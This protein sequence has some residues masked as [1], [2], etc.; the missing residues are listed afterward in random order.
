MTL[1]VRAD[2]SIRATVTPEQ[3]QWTPSPQPGVERV[4]LDRVGAEKARATSLVRYAPASVFPTHTHFG[5][6]EILVLE[7]T[8]S[9]ATGDYSAGY[10][11][12]NPPGS[13]HAPFSAEGALLLV[14]LSQMP[15]D[16]DNPVRV[17][18][19]DDSQWLTLG[20]RRVCP[21]FTSDL[22][23]VVLLNLPAGARV[24]GGPVDGAELLVLEGELNEAQRRYAPR[25][26][27]RLPAGDYP[28][29]CAGEGGAT[30]YLK[31]GAIRPLGA[32]PESVW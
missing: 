25:S 13:Q 27:L 17:N 14:K 9:D 4:M 32:V 18:T 3:H 12:R 20:Q 15:A 2:F 8:F 5:G 28:E 24:L 30:L 11:L 6:E 23:Q 31:T 1:L 19:R 21:L 16:E 29:L 7:G 26:W 10:Y 22:E